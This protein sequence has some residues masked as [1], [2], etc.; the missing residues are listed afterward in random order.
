MKKREAMTVGQII[1]MAIA[2]TGN[3][4]DYDRQRA[5]YMWQEV[6]GPAINRYTTRRWME[7]DKLHVCIVSAPL[8]NELQFTRQRLVENLNRA[9]GKNVISD[10]IIH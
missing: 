6:V 10:I 2:Q 4:D 1:E 3:R 7:R 9:L 5:C 8:K